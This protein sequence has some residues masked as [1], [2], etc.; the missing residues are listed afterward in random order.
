MKIR[1]LRRF[2]KHYSW[3]YDHD[4]QN[5]VL[6]NKK[7]KEKHRRNESFIVICIMMHKFFALSEVISY[8]GRKEKILRRK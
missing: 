6:F 4:R 8:I 2:R 5:W 1:W 3:H 7:T